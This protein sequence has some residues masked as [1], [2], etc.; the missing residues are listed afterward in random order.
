[1]V[2][3]AVAPLPAS[4]EFVPPW[5]RE[6]DR[7]RT[8]LA[9]PDGTRV[10]L[11][12]PVELRLLVE[13]VQPSATVIAGQTGERSAVRF[14][15]GPV[16]AARTV[17]LPGSVGEATTSDGSNIDV[18]RTRAG[19]VALIFALEEW[20]VL[21]EAPDVES[22]TAL[23]AS[24]SVSEDDLGFPIVATVSDLAIDQ[25]ATLTLPHIGSEGVLDLILG[26]CPG[27]QGVDEATTRC[28]AEGR[29]A[30]AV[31]GSDRFAAQLEAGLTIENF[32]S[33]SP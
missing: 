26:P 27:Q 2:V 25:W 18:V 14:V 30:A 12:F 32:S 19:G 24:L 11:T 5:Q 13:G 7:I 4:T 33:P 1:M 22:A 16:E 23:A 21:V 8:T 29:L 10:E 9:F 20:T 15:H 31:T 17:V 3:D 6:G 28:L